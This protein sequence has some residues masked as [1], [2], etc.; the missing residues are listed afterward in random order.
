MRKE[1]LYLMMLTAILFCGP[2]TASAQDEPEFIVTQGDFH[3]LKQKGKTGIV[4]LD[5]DQA[6]IS[7]LHTMEI[8][9]VTVIKHLEEN[10][11]K[12][13]RKWAGIKE[14][15]AE[16]FSDRWNEEKKRYIKLV[17]KGTPDYKL[18][19]KADLFDVGNSA[20]ATWSWNK[21]DGGIIISGTLNVLDANGNNVCKVKINRYRGAST[22]N[23][24]IKAPT[25][26]RRT[27]LFHKSLAKDLLEY[28]DTRK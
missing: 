19:I 10:D 23:L 24:D 12:A 2:L 28:F 26:H 1:R 6:K 27:V 7:N 5:Y 16:M 3:V 11:S 13:F 22:R 21:R 14:E 25:F 18:V 20:S 4:E 15:A 8:S 17:E 9:D